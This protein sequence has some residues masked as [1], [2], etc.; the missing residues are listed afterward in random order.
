MFYEKSADE[1][2]YYFIRRRSSSRAS[3]GHFTPPHFHD[4][5]ELLIVE[6]GSVDAVLNAESRTLSKGEIAFVDKR[7]A[8]S[9][10]FG[11]SVWHSLTFS[12]EYC[13]MLKR[14]GT[15]LPSFP[16]V[17]DAREEILEA[18]TRFY[19][20]NP[21]GNPSAL[22]VESLVCAI[23]ALIEKAAGRIPMREGDA[24]TTRILEY[25]NAHC[26]EPLT[27]RTVAA[28]LGYTPNYFSTLFARLYGM[29][30]KDYLNCIRY[31]SAERMIKAE[32]CSATLAADAAGFGSMNS[33]YRA[34]KRFG[35]KSF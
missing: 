26:G 1:K 27:L 29:S 28:E 9:F 25:I 18:L 20:E 32:G 7:V 6:S 15:T 34:K 10:S 35:E 22:C 19:A 5:Y 30:F 12:E 13:Q 33:F 23:L 21:N 31:R 17:K 11:D 8:H 24:S 3:G 16:D 2:D 4:A 14:G